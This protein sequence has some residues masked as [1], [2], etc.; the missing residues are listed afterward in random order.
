MG[1]ATR[2]PAQASPIEP[3][4]LLQGDLEPGQHSASMA[5]GD[6]ARKN[7]I[8]MKSSIY[9]Q[10]KS[11]KKEDCSGRLYHIP[12]FQVVTVS[13]VYS[14]HDHE[15]IC[16]GMGRIDFKYH[17]VTHPLHCGDHPK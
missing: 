3:C 16:F 12:P 11:I 15:T 13:V 6:N 17:Q 10:S 14:D 5:S 1:I 2:H 8:T 9:N 4:R 7:Y